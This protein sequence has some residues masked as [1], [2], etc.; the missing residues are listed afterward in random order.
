MDSLNIKITAQLNQATSTANIE[1]QLQQIQGKL[2]LKLNLN[3]KPLQESLSKIKDSQGNLL[4]KV[5]T[6][7]NEYGETVQIIDK[8]NK[9]T[10]E[11][12][13]TKKTSTNNNAE[14]KYWK[15]ADKLANDYYKTLDKIKTP[16]QKKIEDATGV[17]AFDQRN[18]QNAK[19][20][21]SVWDNIGTE[22]KRAELEQKKLEESTKRLN[23]QAQS[24]LAQSKY[25]S[26]NQSFF[27]NGTFDTKAFNKSIGIG[28]TT[29]I[30]AQNSA[31]VEL[32]NKADKG[33]QGFSKLE[34]KVIKTNKAFKDSSSATAKASKSMADLNKTTEKSAQSMS[35][36]LGK[37]AKWGL[38]TTAI[39]AP[40]RAFKDGIETLKELDS[41]LT[42][43][44]K[45]T[46]LTNT[47]LA[48]LAKNSFQIA[49]NYGR[50]SQD[51]LSGIAEFSRAGYDQASGKLSELSILAQNVGELTSD[52]ANKF[53]LATD[54]AYKYAGSQEKLLAVLDGANQ[55]DNKFATSIS[56]IS[57]GMTRA[58][59][60]ASNSGIQVNE[61]ASAIGVMTAKTQRSGSEAGNALKGILMNIRAV[62]G[63]LDNGEVIDDASISKSADALASVNIKVHELRNGVEELRNPMDVLKE[64]SAKWK[65]LSTIDQSKLI[66]AI[67]GKYRG[68]FLTALLENY[69]TYEKML[70]EYANASGSATKENE[71]RMQSWQA[72]LNQLTNTVSEFWYKT[73]DTNAFKKMID[74]TNSLVKSLDNL[75]NNP[76]T[77][78]IAV[79]GLGAL[80]GKALA[81]AFANVSTGGL[82]YQIALFRMSVA[83]EGLIATTKI[84]TASL[85][86]SPLFIG[87][88]IALSIYAIAK[89][90]D[91]TTVSF[92]EQKKMVEDLSGELQSLQSEYDQL[93]GKNY[94]TD[95]EQKK[96]D[97]LGKQIK[98]KQDLLELEK[99]IE[100][101]KYVGEY[102][103]RSGGGS[104]AN[105]KSGVGGSQSLSKL[106]KANQQI[107][108]YKS[109]LKEL[110]SIQS[111]I[112]KEQN[113][114]KREKLQK[115]YDNLSEKVAKAK[116]SFTELYSSMTDEQSKGAK[117]TSEM[118]QQY[119][120]LGSLINA[121]DESSNGNVVLANSYGLVSDALD[122]VTEKKSLTKKETD[123]LVTLYPE[124]ADVVSKTSDGFYIEA[125]A[126][127]NLSD[128]A[129]QSAISQINTQITLTK[130]VIDQT[131]KRISAMQLEAQAQQKI[132]NISAGSNSTFE[133]YASKMTGK[134]VKLPTDS[135]VN[136]IAKDNLTNLEGLLGKLNA[137]KAGSS[138]LG[139]GG[140]A[141]SGDKDKSSS[142]PS[143]IEWTD[144]S[145]AIVDTI[146]QQVKL[147]TIQNE[148]LERQLKVVEASKDYTKQIELQNQLL[149]NQ[150]KT[151]SDLKTANDK[152]HAQAES[153]RSKTKY[154]TESWFN[155]DNTDT[156]SYLALLNSFAGKT[157]DASKNAVEK[158]KAIHD[159]LKTL[160]DGWM[161][162]KDAI[163]SMNSSMQTT[164]DTIND[165][166]IKA[167]ETQKDA[168]QEIIDLTV[169]LIKK[170]K[171]DEKQAIQDKIDAYKDYIDLQKESLELREKE[172]SYDESVDEKTNEIAKLQK[173]ADTLGLDDSR[174]AQSQRA[175]IL[176][177]I[178]EKQKDLNQYQHDDAVEKQ[179]SA[180]DKQLES[181]ENEKD[182]EI[183]EIE[184]YLNKTGQLTRDAMRR[185]DN[186]GYSLYQDLI[187]YNAEY[188]DKLESEIVSA[189]ESATKAL[190]QYGSTL[191]AITSMNN[192]INAHS[193]DSTNSSSSKSDVIS[194]M[195]ANAKA[196]FDANGDER[197][198][199]SA[200]ND[201][202]GASI[203]AYKDYSSG[204]W[205]TDYTKKT[206]LFHNGYESG[207][208]GGNVPIS[209][210][211]NELLALL[212]DDELVFN[213]DQQ[214]R[215]FDGMNMFKNIVQPMNT[216]FASSINNN[217]GIHLTVEAPVTITGNAD[218]STIQ[219]L[220]KF[221][222][223]LVDKTIT[224]LNTS[225]N[226]KGLNFGI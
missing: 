171:E 125:D 17:T 141:S 154:N 29:G 34:D 14:L 223:S 188:G 200:Q 116:A 159:Q 67:G 114:D 148:S 128:T 85:L 222:D 91:A 49:S 107:E 123:Q 137:I 213:K 139:S 161:S 103:K 121:T 47:Q 60:I 190:E 142:T 54:S 209:L 39:Y 156:T 170:E 189:W 143:A 87:S 135:N 117:F 127:S 191:N 38:A 153:V 204:K 185:I 145:Q 40:I 124:L 12:E 63:G 8:L 178:A 80:A 1:K 5:K 89:A 37:I 201:S 94:L 2:N 43:I 21:Q 73:L 65:D 165:L 169:E 187:N 111:K 104:T 68:N 35:S 202:L 167:L 186:D 206:P 211:Q 218:S 119:N 225:F 129:R 197:K 42:E 84:L 162:N 53:L 7:K 71:R 102:I 109:N 55:I 20:Y 41:Q 177:Q 208:V 16:M 163:D 13:Q 205:Y 130:N 113:A 46:N 4:K 23:Y 180:L 57:D 131:Q 56:A 174:E 36:V 45:V 93:S 147:D 220:E 164:V 183:K 133:K 150:Q 31:L 77:K 108:K 132:A 214:E 192:A 52:Q 81:L 61:L 134:N 62:H 184:N 24:K 196:W 101:E 83:Q 106:D 217:N 226:L 99:K 75:V 78:W 66:E 138:S 158:I 157:D 44:G 176:E 193:S 100:G 110:D 175:D 112:D 181:F 219:Q 33:S 6:T 3:T 152:I 144:E 140:I 182:E 168:L 97:I 90:I 15:E 118:Q 19:T 69:S 122:K 216:N 221:G 195:Q 72:K 26:T 28:Q 198:R 194:Q 95:E 155:A 11:W 58:G 64:L 10:Q 27:N 151:V 32:F 70:T 173:Q 86:T 126:L 207:F 50:T 210:K 48:N 146:N 96:L 76:M 166:K 22:I 59:S 203:N 51:Y 30:K 105:D 224:K 212:Q 215:L 25:N 18:I 199:L 172:A 136:S 149:S 179:Q 74:S 9:K 160:K 79:A 92:A 82:A 120:V 115:Q 98:A 88:A